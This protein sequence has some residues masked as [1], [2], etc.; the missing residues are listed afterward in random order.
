MFFSMLKRLSG[1]TGKKKKLP[2]AEVDRL[3]EVA[4]EAGKAGDNRKAIPLIRQILETQPYHAHALNDLGVCLSNIGQMEEAARYFELSYSLDD[5]YIAAITN[6]AK[7]LISHRKAG[8]A[9]ACLRQGRIVEPEFVHTDAVYGEYCILA[10]DPDR[11]RSLAMNAWLANF[12][13]LRYVNSVLFYSAYCDMP[14]QRLAAEHRFWADTLMP[15]PATIAAIETSVDR[16]PDQ[17][18]KIRIGYWSPDFRDHSVRYFVRPLLENHDREK[19]EVFL[20]HDFPGRDS[21]TQAIELCADHFH[22]VAGLFDEDVCR[23]LASHDLDVLVELAGHTSVNRINLLQKRWA[24]LQVSGLGYPPT[25]GL[26]SIDAKMMDVHIV[27]DDS[28]RLHVEEPLVLPE[29]FWCFDPMQDVPDATEPPVIKNGYVTFGAVGNLSKITDRNLE[30]WAQIMSR[31]PR[32]RLS[33]R[34][35]ALVDPT[36]AATFRRRLVKADLPLNRVDL[37]LPVSGGDLFGSYSEIDIVLDTYPFNGGTTSC[38][39][40]YMGVPMVTQSGDSLISRVGRSMLRNMGASHLAVDTQARYVETAI[41]LSQNIRFLKEFRVDARR[42]MKA[43]AL[44]NGEIFA[45]HFESAILQALEKKANSSRRSVSRAVEVLPAEEIVLRAYRIAA[46]NQPVA[47]QRVVEYCLRHYPDSAGA[48]IL[49]SG[50]YSGRG[51]FSAAAAY[52]RGIIERASEQDKPALLLNICR[53]QL[54]AG[55]VTAARESVA[56]LLQCAEA[57]KADL[58]QARLYAASWAAPATSRRGAATVLTTGRVVHIAVMCDAAEAF[59]QAKAHIEQLCLLPSGCTLR[60]SR[61][62]VADFSGFIRS[63]EVSLDDAVVLL[64]PHMQIASASF[65]VEILAAL[66]VGDVVG[67]YGAREWIRLDW[68]LQSFETKAGGYL[69]LSGEREGYCEYRVMGIEST[70]I[71]PGLA[72]LSGGIMAARAQTLQEVEFDPILAEAGSLWEQAWSFEA[73]K[74]RFRV[75]AHAALGV[76]PAGETASAVE[77]TAGRTYLADQYGLQVLDVDDA[78]TQSLSLPAESAEKAMDAVRTYFAA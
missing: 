21:H 29:S 68:H 42:R 75:I 9:L 17:P 13:N 36:C 43:S 12:E 77:M 69:F 14:E 50:Q 64:R 24:R 30:A 52:L 33:I 18:R 15:L 34:S 60:F 16:L 76:V 31:V 22:D 41:S 71:T 66:E 62:K 7:T 2:V 44:G 53:N 56:D 58:A 74:R 5:T 57:T 28:A 27:T 26:S 49:A 63:P 19:F 40:L 72:V 55:D 46:A 4:V 61:V 1:Q 39:S 51:D 25:T 11:A 47:A 8:E 20:Y 48:H 32:S 38:F 65:I 70:P 67:F 45:A 73:G 10:G 37:K 3:L 23:L 54:L 6:H 59:N 35:I 78:D